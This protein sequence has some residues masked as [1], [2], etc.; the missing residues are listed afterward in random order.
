MKAQMNYRISK[1]L[2]MLSLG[3]IGTGI[4]I[5]VVEYDSVTLQTQMVAPITL[6]LAAMTLVLS[7]VMHAHATRQRKL[8]EFTQ[9]KVR[10]IQLRSSEAFVHECCLTG[11]HRI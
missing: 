10:S 11:M 4:Y 3:I 5:G 8:D 7:Y 9:E 1:C 6:L 2:M